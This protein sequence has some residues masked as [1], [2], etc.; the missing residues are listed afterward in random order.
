M[1][2]V[3]ECKNF[4]SNINETNICTKDDSHRSPCKGDY[5][6]PLTVID[7]NNSKV[8]IAIVSYN[9]NYGCG[10]THPAVYTRVS[11]YREW[12]RKRTNI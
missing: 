6:G 2:P 3:D 11:S 4:Y 9:F 12:I 7:E 10:D 1:I 5:G 8:L